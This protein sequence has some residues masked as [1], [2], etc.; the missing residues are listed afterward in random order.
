[1]AVGRSL[2]QSFEWLFHN[3]SETHHFTDHAKNNWENPFW[4][5]RNLWSEHRI[6]FIQKRILTLGA[7]MQKCSLKPGVWQKVVR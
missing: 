6:E 5:M 4:N 1:M 7:A 3:F 2:I